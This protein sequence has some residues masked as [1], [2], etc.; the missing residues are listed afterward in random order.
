MLYFYSVEMK[1]PMKH[2]FLGGGSWKDPEKLTLNIT[3]SIIYICGLLLFQVSSSKLCYQF[4]MI[5][6]SASDYLLLNTHVS[7]LVG[8]IMN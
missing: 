4:L 6:R 1:H 8:N 7:L 3:L 2:R 5:L